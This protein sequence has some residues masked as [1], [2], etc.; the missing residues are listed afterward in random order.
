V[1]QVHHAKSNRHMGPRI[2]PNCPILHGSDNTPDP[3]TAVIICAELLHTVPA[4]NLKLVLDQ[5][6]STVRVVICGN[7]PTRVDEEYYK[8]INT[9]FQPVRLGFP[10]SSKSIFDPCSI[11]MVPGMAWG[12]PVGCSKSPMVT[13]DG[14]IRE[15]LLR[16]IL[17]DLYRVL[18]SADTIATRYLRLYTRLCYGLSRR[19]VLFV[20]SFSVP[21]IGD[22]SPN[23]Y[24]TWHSSL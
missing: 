23:F 19:G 2:H 4:R 10:S 21:Q 5:N 1:N 11:S 3:I 8:H 20:T 22:S 12:G 15:S 7:V 24:C 6:W 14:S 16:L 9:E 17:I 13:V 18:N